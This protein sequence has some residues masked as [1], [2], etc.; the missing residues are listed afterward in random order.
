MMAIAFVQ[1]REARTERIAAATALKAAD[2]AEEKAAEVSGALR[3]QFLLVAS[4]TWLQLETKNEFGTEHSK[5]AV[6]EMLKD[7]NSLLPKVIPDPIERRDWI[8]A[9][10]QRLPPK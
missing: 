4:V 3:E 9:L 1:L 6:D 2:A 5:R 8:A 7:I 10:Q